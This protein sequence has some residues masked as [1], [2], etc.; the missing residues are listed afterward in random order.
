MKRNISLVGTVALTALSYGDI[1]VG[2][3]ETRE[4][5]VPSGQTAAV[6]ERVVIGDG[7]VL[8]K[9]GKGELTLP[10]SRIDRQ[11][12]YSIVALD[13]KLKI[14]PGEKPEG[15][16]VPS[17]V[18]GAAIWLKADSNLDVA[19]DGQVT[20]WSDARETSLASRRY[21][22]ALASTRFTQS[23][24]MTSNVWNN[25]CVYFG[26][27]GSGQGMQFKT[28]ADS[29][30]NLNY[31][32]AVFA[33][34]GAQETWSSPLGCVGVNNYNSGIVMS[35]ADLSN[36]DSY[37]FQYEHGMRGDQNGGVWT[38]RNMIDGEARD[39]FWTKPPKGFHLLSSVMG[40]A[41]LSLNSL[42]L[43]RTQDKSYSGGD[44]LSEVIVFTNALTAA[45][46]V[47]VEHYLMGKWNLRYDPTEG[48][49]GGIVGLDR[50]VGHVGSAAGATVEFDVAE[51]EESSPVS[52]NGEGTIV[53]NGPGTLVLG[54]SGDK[55]FAGQFR[56]NEGRVI[57][58]GGLAPDLVVSG[59]DE[60]ASDYLSHGRDAS[61]AEQLSAGVAL[62]VARNAAGAGIV[63]KTGE[64][65]ARVSEVSANVAAIKVD[66]GKLVLSAPLTT[67]QYETPEAETVSVTVANADFEEYGRL[68]PSYTLQKFTDGVELCG[69]YGNSDWVRYAPFSTL[70]SYSLIDGPAEGKS[71]L[72]LKG[73][74]KAWTFV[75]FPCSGEY[76]VSVM[77]TKRFNDK[78]SAYHYALCL[79][80]DG[81]SV[82]AARVVG[83]LISS[84]GSAWT[85]YQFKVNVNESGRHLLGFRPYPAASSY[86]ADDDFYFDD[87][88]VHYVA[89]RRHVPTVGIPNGD[90]EEYAAGSQFYDGLNKNAT[91]EG[92]SFDYSG[93][94]VSSDSNPA[95]ALANAS[96]YA[97]S[98][99]K[100]THMFASD[101]ASY[102][103]SH[104]VFVG[105]GGRARTTFRVPAGTYQ[106]T[107]R[108]ACWNS[109][110][111]LGGSRTAFL[112]TSRVHAD[113]V[114]SDKVTSL[115]E[116]TTLSHAFTTVAWGGAFTLDE[117]MDVTLILSGDASAVSLV[118]DLALDAVTNVDRG[119]LV[120][121]GSGEQYGS[122]MTQATEWNVFFPA[123]GE[124][125]G[126]KRRSHLL[127][128]AASVWGYTAYSGQRALQIGENAGLKQAVT[129]PSAGVYCL[130]FAGKTRSDNPQGSGRNPICAMLLS[131]SGATNVITRVKPFSCNYA[132]YAAYF[133]VETAGTYDLV[134]RG[135]TLPGQSGDSD[136]AS[137]IDGVS[138]RKVSGDLAEFPRM[139]KAMDTEISVARG[140]CIQLDYP[141]QMRV[142]AVKLGGVKAYGVIDAEHYPDY[143]TGM[144]SLLTREP[145]LLVIFR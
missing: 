72:Q 118:D 127:L 68:N 92:W 138:I 20:R 66:A 145:G 126:Y 83:H 144:G 25:A 5:S 61:R 14:E 35:T 6:E 81:T 141:G 71:A 38:A 49:D 60:I 116:A 75:D 136:R 100:P 135:T 32:T 107:G 40:T 21:P 119:E 65:E 30:L 58:R 88:K 13:G 137:Q 94:S 121:D 89:A 95:V 34:F 132:E 1:T 4:L 69:W 86:Y 130:R 2:W 26:G 124:Q 28:A 16:D 112:A 84:K 120:K 46:I 52:L 11:G 12:P 80:K 98:A 105:E 62:S 143:V 131:A 77:S 3:K 39:L 31:V 85:R 140:A 27:L 33:V 9:T 47:S 48:P 74:S 36:P 67:D 42:Y 43:R 134:L 110:Y 125:G 10:A 53:K 117:E 139:P 99:A 106:L 97:K 76:E 108:L 23:K 129:F 102:G 123:E 87:L 113:V 96:R 22:S 82:D 104:L 79:E 45:Q 142:G 17:V 128:G 93:A 111:D 122:T 50:D 91:P 115:G 8:Y 103:S 59:G 41:P 90:F 55:T 57:L 51:N 18:S 19:G 73:G 56:L 109:E 63:R 15:L 64:G 114:I 24:P 37:F 7:G 101:G 44:F 29:D 133:K 78:N 70:L 54:P